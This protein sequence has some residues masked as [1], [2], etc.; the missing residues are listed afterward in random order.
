MPSSPPTT[1][2]HCFLPAGARLFSA[3]DAGDAAYLIVT[4]Q[5]EIVLERAEGDLVLAH[6]G[7]GEIVGEMAIL[8]HQPRS[9]A[10]RALSDCKLVIITEEQIAHRIAQ[11]DPILRMCLGVVLSRYRQTVAILEQMQGSVP[12]PIPG[13][14]SPPSEL[15]ASALETLSLEREIRAG[16]QNGEFELFFQ[17]IVRLSNRRLAGFEAL[18]RWRHP[19]RGLV[20]PIAFIPAAEAS[21]LIVE[22]TARA[23]AEVGRVFP[24]MMLAALNNPHALDGPLFMTVNVSGRDLA[25]ASF[26]EMIAEF[27]ER[28]QIP[29]GSLK[30]E[31]TESMLMD[32]PERATATLEQCRNTG[33]GIAI[34][35]FGTGYSS[36]SYL[37]TLPVTTL[38]IDRAFVRTLL[39]DQTSRDIVQTI[40]RLA[41][42]LSV[43]VVAE[44]IEQGAEADVLGAMG[45]AFGQGYH[46]GRPVPLSETMQVI[47]NWAAEPSAPR[48][49]DLRVSA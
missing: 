29:P 24:E 18:M 36:L 22:L 31:V 46:F 10:V 2:D 30:I 17:P 34:D 14:D 25:G 1:P 28:T 48:I 38:K 15:V 49:A 9:A 43:T 16:L 13:A 37:S 27:L 8:D 33:L 44:G 26:P 4:G 7:P 40:L 12:P 23:F 21:G 20:P 39:A 41:D 42:D 35:D 32:D 3:G 45:C 11:T 47:A 19:T 6:R 5:L